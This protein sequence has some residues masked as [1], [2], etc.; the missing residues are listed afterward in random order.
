[1]SVFNS[2]NNKIK[3]LILKFFDTFGYRLRGIKKIVQHNNFDSI[4]KFII[5]G[6]ENKNHLMIFDVGANVGQSIDR[7]RSNF[8]NC[9]I[10]S[11]E[12]SKKIFE[13]L[14]KNK[15]KK[16]NFL[17]NL[18][19]TEKAETKVLNSFEYHHINSFYELEKNSKFE[20]S[21]KLSSNED[22]KFQTKEEVKCISLDEFVKLNNV[23]QID[24]LKIDTQGSE[25][26][27]LKG[28][29]SLL[30]KQRISLIEVELIIGVAYERRLNFYDLEK[31]LIKYGYRLI[32]ISEGGN[33]ISYSSY[34]VD[35]IYVNEKIYKKI[36]E[37][38]K[39]NLNI[40]NVM[41]KVSKLNKST[42]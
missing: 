2:I 7:F 9:S 42:Y 15:K 8:N 32:A 16:N 29:E 12:P 39:K 10:Y 22:K 38:D 11:F 34:Q 36:I 23:G 41:K 13:I 4:H 3:N 5:E 35:L 40:S 28:A 1:M 27:V 18:A 20:L 26:E 24:I 6:L 33:V 30:L 25:P 37:L 31:F 14:N 17:F 19:L 21:R